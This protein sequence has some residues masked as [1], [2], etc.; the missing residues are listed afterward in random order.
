MLKTDDFDFHLPEELI[1]K[2]PFFPKELTK[3]LVFDNN[4]ISDAKIKDLIG[5]LQKG[6]VVVFNDTKVIKAKLQG[7]RYLD[8]GVFANIEINLHKNI[9][10]FTW[11]VMAKPAK[12]LQIGQEIKFSADFSAI[13]TK[14]Y[15]SIFFAFKFNAKSEEFFDKLEKYGQMPLPPYIKR[16]KKA[17]NDNDNMNY[18][19][20]F[21]KNKGA[22]A[23][24]TAG[25]HFTQEILDRIKNKGVKQAFV[26]LNVGAGTFLPVKSE[27]IKDHQM[28]SEYFTIKQEACD[29]INE[30]K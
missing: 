3:M 8:N 29:I 25:L 22:V 7:K 5:Y 19:T 20:I 21:A 18:Q 23:A 2:Q 1:A 12:R 6:D 24:P 16:D 9:D 10:E 4:N 28:H 11:Q 13:V 14:K 15:D 17:K 30:A 27:F 26:T